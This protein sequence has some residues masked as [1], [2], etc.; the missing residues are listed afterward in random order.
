[1]PRF[2]GPLAANGPSWNGSPARKH[3]S[4][5][6]GSVAE[7]VWDPARRLGALETDSCF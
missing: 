5:A 6:P 2:N 7:T 3:D 1:M 4:H